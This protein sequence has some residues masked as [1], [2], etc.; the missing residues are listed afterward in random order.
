VWII[1]LYIVAK[2]DEMAGNDRRLIEM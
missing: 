2:S 1:F